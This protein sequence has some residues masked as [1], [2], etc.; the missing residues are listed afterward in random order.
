[1]YMYIYIYICRKEKGSEA[2]GE[3]LPVAYFE[4]DKER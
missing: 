1:M 2:V 4:P 3:L